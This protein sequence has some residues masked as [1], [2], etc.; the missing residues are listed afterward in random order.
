MGWQYYFT[1]IIILFIRWV[2]S[3]EL[4]FYLWINELR[5]SSDVVLH[6]S[7][8]EWKWEKSVVLPHLHSI[9]LM[10][11]T[12]SELGLTCG[13][14]CLLVLKSALALFTYVEKFSLN[15]SSSSF[16]IRVNLLHPSP[17]LFL[18]GL[19]LSL[20]C[21]SFIA[22]YYFQVSFNFKVKSWLSSSNVSTF[23]L[24]QSMLILISI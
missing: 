15:V 5:P 1:R 17:S 23:P 14:F 2:K 12:A 10:W 8:I 6:M 16:V 11:S 21:F 18:Y 3:L 22:K 20:W 7:R 13:H 9:R 24:I 4:G 19:L